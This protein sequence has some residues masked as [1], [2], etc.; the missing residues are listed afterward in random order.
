MIKAWRQPTKAEI[1]F[2]YGAIHYADFDR[3]VWLR[4]GPLW[5]SVRASIALPG[6]ITPSHANGDW[7]VDGGLVNPVPVSLCKALGAD[8]VIAVNLNSDIVGRHFIDRTEVAKNKPPKSTEA[9]LLDKL[10]V[11]LKRRAAP[12]APGL[13]D[14]L[15]GSLNIMQHQIT[16]SRMVESRA[17]VLIAPKLAHIGLLEFDRAQEAIVEGRECVRRMT[18]G[19]RE[20]LAERG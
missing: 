13:F 6:I 20:L 18:P 3:E 11:R 16:G 12:E 15:A 17:D 19:L 1:R 8:I 7:L 2:G 5:D 14:V 10:T 9:K 4:N